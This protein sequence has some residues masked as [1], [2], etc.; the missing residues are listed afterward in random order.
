MSEN[1]AWNEQSASGA[2]EKVIGRNQ[3]TARKQTRRLEISPNKK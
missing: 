1:D 3:P 2:C